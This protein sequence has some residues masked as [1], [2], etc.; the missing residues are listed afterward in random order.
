MLASGS[1][2]VTRILRSGTGGVRQVLLRNLSS[3]RVHRFVRVLSIVRAGLIGAN[4]VKSRDQCSDLRVR[5]RS[6]NR[7]RISR[8]PRIS[9]RSR[10]SYSK[11][12]PRGHSSRSRCISHVLQVSRRVTVTG[13]LEWRA[14]TD[15]CRGR[16]AEDSDNGHGSIRGI[17]AGTAH[18]S[19]AKRVP[20]QVRG[21]RP[22]LPNVHDHKGHTKGPCSSY[23]NVTS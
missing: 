10:R 8:G 13:G 14:W 20:T 6:F 22:T 21:D 2:R 19:R 5:R 17:G 11:Q 4:L 16:E 23:R 7:S 3:S 1:E 9:R 12:G 15:G 18:R